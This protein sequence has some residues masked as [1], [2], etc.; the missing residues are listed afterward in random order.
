MPFKPAVVKRKFLGRSRGGCK[1]CRARRVKCDE[2]RPIC[3]ACSRRK[4]ECLWDSSNS[5]ND[6]FSTFLT[7]AAIRMLSIPPKCQRSLNP[8]TGFD[9]K[10]LELL[11]NWVTH[12]IMSIVPNYDGSQY[13]YTI[14]APKLAFEHKTLLHAIFALSALQLHSCRPDGNYLTY[15]RLHCQKTLLGLRGDA[16]PIPPDV[17]FLIN[18]ILATYWASSPAWDT[19]SGTPSIFNWFPAARR[20]ITRGVPYWM[21]VVN[22]RR[23]SSIFLPS[24]IVNAAYSPLPLPGLLP[25]LL[26][27]AACPFDPD[28]LKDSEVVADYE[29][30]L[31]MLSFCWNLSTSPFTEVV[32]LFHFP[33][34]C[35]DSFC[36]RVL[37]K[38]P[39]ALVII[40]HYLALLSHLNLGE[41]WVKD[42]MRRITES[43]APEWV[44]W[45]NFSLA[46]LNMGVPISEALSFGVPISSTISN[47]LGQNVDLSVSGVSPPQ[48]SEVQHV[49]IPLNTA[50]DVVLGQE[51][52]DWRTLDATF[53]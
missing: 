42:D 53:S 9:V 38:Q 11:N 1:T 30:S 36:E 31:A 47:P 40:A 22:G 18:L 51:N 45:L 20:F 44:P 39:R 5:R 16:P 8:F 50:P 17:E 29:N 28:E 32:A 7:E 26:D 35:A 10:D 13:A 19:P 12:T 41:S 14:F 37:S 46:M 2:L 21:D 48:S 33:G 52:F 24:F 34:A 43:L 27:S 23:N 3:K 25:F 49:C 15:A 4:E 6:P